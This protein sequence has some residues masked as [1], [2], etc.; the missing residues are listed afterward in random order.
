MRPARFP[1]QALAGGMGGRFGV[2]VVKLGFAARERPLM[3]QE[4][5]LLGE[6]HGLGRYKMVHTPT[7]VFFRKDINP[8]D[9][10]RDL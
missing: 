5:S 3:P 1:P 2:M 8:W 10:L 9:L 6:L 7:P 4:W